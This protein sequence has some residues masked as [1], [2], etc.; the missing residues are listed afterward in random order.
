MITFQSEF[1]GE[2][3]YPARSPYKPEDILLFD[4]ETTGLSASTSFLYLIGCSY[5]Q[6]N[7]WHLV[8]WLAD[9]MNSEAALLDAFTQKAAGYKR[10]LTYNGST[11]DL[12]YLLHKCRQH[13][14][15]FKIMD[16]YDIYKKLLPCKKYLPVE[17]LKQKTLEEFLQIERRDTYTGEQL[18]QV[19]SNYLGTKQYEK[20]R[21]ENAGAGSNLLSGKNMGI[22]EG[23]ESL[24]SSLELQ[25]ILL[26]HNLEDLKGLL[27]IS[28]MLWYP[29]LSE[30]KA[31]DYE[32]TDSSLAKEKFRITVSLPFTLPRPLLW[33]SP[34][35]DS[36]LELKL[37]KNLLVL[38]IPLIEGELKY[39]YEDY[40]DYYYLP[41]EDMAV[42]KNLAQY[43]DK[44]YRTRAKP[45]N[46]YTRQRGVF[47]PQ[48]ALVLSPFLK[49]DYADKITYISAANPS[50]LD[51]AV[52]QEYIHSLVQYITH[53]RE[54]KIIS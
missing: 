27:G 15:D 11:F 54:T 18:I 50:L 40:R 20:L 19:Y 23:Q 22:K 46:C 47:L 38:Q 45:S 13:G 24:P 5:Y 30:L 34:L 51:T 43:V 53:N 41:K 10:L 2:L 21:Q 1:H 37:E 49:K 32:V 28:S 31:T 25:N 44:D 4:I 16:S 48:P 9:D 7:S 26:L 14:L 52:I 29:R 12:P 39:F 3:S 42:H 36:L 17:N 35:S 6:D 33:Q 8:Q